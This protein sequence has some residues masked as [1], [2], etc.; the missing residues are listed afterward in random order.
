MQAAALPASP[1]EKSA[2]R[3]WLRALEKTAKIDAAP[4]RIFPLVVEELGARF[5]DAPALLSSS[6]NFSHAQLAARANQ[7]ARWALAQ[8]VA[9]G[10]T[11]ALLMP[12]RAEYLA[13]WLGI[14]RIGGVVALINTNLSGAALAHS[15]TI[16]GPK[17]LIVATRLDAVLEG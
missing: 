5:G 10:D 11:V 14:S 17:H 8:G 4:A 1:T 12:N 9:K 6:E 7:Y 13:I 16:A 2:S 3:A 15:L